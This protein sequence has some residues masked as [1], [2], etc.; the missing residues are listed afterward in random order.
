MTCTVQLVGS[1]SVGGSCGCTGFTAGGSAPSSK[2]MGL[3][4][5]CTGT[6]YGAVNSS[7]CPININT[8]TF[9]ELPGSDAVGDFQ[10]VS[11]KSSSLVTLRVG[12]AAA[13]VSGVGGSFPTGFSG[14]EAFDFDVDGTNVAGTFTVAAQNITDVLSE[15]NQAA[16]AAGL[17][18]L[19]FTASTS[20]QVTVTGVATGSDGS[21]VVNTTIAALGFTAA[22]TVFGSGDDLA[23]NGLFL[24]QFNPTSAPTRIQ[25]MGI[26]QVEILLAGAAPS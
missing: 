4:F 16:I 25:I 14:G 8:A 21:V 5:S 6:T 9:I 12:A 15:L 1:V 26:A 18:Y 19:P 3:S 7:D 20:G 10:L 23:V 22:T 24:S 11:I 13:T 17:A 2:T